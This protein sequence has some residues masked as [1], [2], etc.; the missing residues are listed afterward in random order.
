M[1]KK[2]AKSSSNPFGMKRTRSPVNILVVHFSYDDS[3]NDD[4]NFNQNLK[5]VQTKLDM[6]ISPFI[7]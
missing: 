3:G 4:L 7:T 6:W 5:V 2:W 1:F